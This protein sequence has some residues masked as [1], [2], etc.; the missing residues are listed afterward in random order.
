MSTPDSNTFFD[1]IQQPSLS[2]EIDQLK[3][4]VNAPLAVVVWHDVYSFCSKLGFSAGNWIGVIFN[5]SMMA[6]TGIVVIKIGKELFGQDEYRLRRMGTLFCLCGL[7]W[8]FGALFIRD[9]FVALINTLVLW[10]IIRFINDS[11][12]INLVINCLIFLVSLYSLDYLRHESIYVLY[13][14]YFVAMAVWVIKKETTFPAAVMLFLSFIFLTI[15]LYPKVSMIVSGAL[16]AS[17]EGRE[18]YGL[19]SSMNHD[20]SSLGLNLIVNQPMPVRA[21]MGIGYL[22]INPVPMWS[23]F[24]TNLGEYFWIKG[25]Q[26]LYMLFLFPMAFLGSRMLFSS[27]GALV[28]QNK[29]VAF[30]F[31]VA[32]SVVTLLMV[33]LTS[34][35]TRHYGQFM[36]SIIVLAAIPD[37][38]SI[39][40][41]SLLA[42]SI[43]IWFAVVVFVHIMWAAIKF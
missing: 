43:R 36:S 35:E 16:N 37:S 4:I 38:R 22:L 29:K 9:C 33:S 14:I 17:V 32:Y 13:V 10:G 23:Y 27:F 19:M 42:L 2:S 18:Q 25:W 3:M 15:I 5:A 11:K 24:N 26:G 30:N 12:L 31:L 28:S 40:D 6:V 41:R 7:T 34:L 1:L 8:L 21:I 39:I 20:T